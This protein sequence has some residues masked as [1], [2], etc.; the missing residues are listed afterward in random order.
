MLCD[1]TYRRFL[2]TEVEIVTQG[3]GRG[4]EWVFD[5]DGISVGKMESSGGGRGMGA[6]PVNSSGA[7]LHIFTTPTKKHQLK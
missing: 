4:R 6:Q 2:E 1:S 3:W 5:R 7:S